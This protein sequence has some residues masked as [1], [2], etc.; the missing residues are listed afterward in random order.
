VKLSSCGEQ[1][2]TSTEEENVSDNSSMQHG[3]WAKS[4]AEQPCFPFTGKPGIN[5]DLQDPSTPWNILNCSIH[6]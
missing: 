3:I 1:S 6:K 5:V 4:G 2:V